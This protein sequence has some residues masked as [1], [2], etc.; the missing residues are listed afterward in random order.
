MQGVWVWKEER[1]KVL[2]QYLG[3]NTFILKVS[4][5]VTRHFN[6]FW[7]M[8]II[9]RIIWWGI[10]VTIV[11]LMSKAY[12]NY[13]RSLTEMTK[14]CFHGWGRS[15]KHWLRKQSSLLN[16]ISVVQKTYKSDLHV[17]R[18]HHQAT[19]HLLILLIATNPPA[20]SLTQTGKP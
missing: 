11:F 10:P 8:S 13:S 12:L 14:V 16:V 5:Q 3:V 18:G 6:R 19:F 4:E 7:L 15:I 17:N 1:K 9:L 20:C 2:W